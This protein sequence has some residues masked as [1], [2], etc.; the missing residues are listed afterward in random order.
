MKGLWLLPSLA[1]ATLCAFPLLAQE[2]AGSGAGGAFLGNEGCFDCH[3]QADLKMA[4]NV[5]MRIERFEVRGHE[6]GCE[7]CHGPGQRH[8]DEGDPGLIRTFSEESPADG[9]CLECHRTKH[10][11][12]WQAS[13]HAVEEVSC[14]SCHPSH[15]VDVKP[16]ESCNEC[17]GEQVARFQLPSH[18][19][20][21]E[22]KMSCSS[23]H[24]THAATEA[25]LKTRM[26]SNDLCYTCHQAIEG[27][28]I[29]EHAPVEEDCSLCHTPHGSVVD[30]LLVAN[31]PML[32][33]QC[34][35]FHFHAGYQASDNR[36][37]EIGGIER[38]NPFG[39]QGFNIA[40][41]T[42]CTQC[43]DRI[44]GSDLPSQTTTGMGKGLTQ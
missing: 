44:H 36:E 29:F 37:V 35:D 6:V 2:A 20:L 34:H 4:K 12:E 18:H 8:A 42:S 23:C 41:T 11:P 32:C 40:F 22:G 38:E 7:G 19:P 14:Q 31:E 15:E 25:M 16:E 28:H 26:R 9:V 1:L 43:H 5:H 30:N 13:L 33:L 3:E 27:P 17:H 24:D 21:R 39:S 10:M